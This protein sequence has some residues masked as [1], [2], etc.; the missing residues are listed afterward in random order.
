MKSIIAIK[1]EI[2]TKHP[3][4]RLQRACAHIDKAITALDRAQADLVGIQGMED[5]RASI[6]ELLGGRL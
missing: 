4:F 6:I 3:D 2:R 1:N 5:I